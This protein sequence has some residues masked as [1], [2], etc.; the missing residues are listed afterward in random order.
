MYEDFKADLKVECQ[1]T[2]APGVLRFTPNFDMP[3]IMYYQ[4]FSEK[5]LGGK[6]HLLEQCHEILKST[7]ADSVTRNKKRKP[8]KQAVKPYQ[9][10]APQTNY[11]SSS[12]TM[13]T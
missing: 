2:G 8:A 5:L 3:D 10:K 4:S 13:S 9:D 6:I 12:K 7:E 11:H 1:E